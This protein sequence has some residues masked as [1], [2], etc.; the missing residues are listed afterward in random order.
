MHFEVASLDHSQEIR[1]YDIHSGKLK[2]IYL[3]HAKTQKGYKPTITE[4][5]I[6]AGQRKVYLSYSSGDIFLYNSKNMEFI[7]NVNNLDEDYQ[8]ILKQE[9]LALCPPEISSLTSAE[10]SKMLYLPDDEVLIV[11]TASGVIKLYNEGTGETGLIKV[12]VGGHLGSEITML[13]YCKKARLLVSGS[14]NGIATIWNLNTNKLEHVCYSHP[15]KIVGA[16]ILLP[17]PLVVI[18]NQVG[19]ITVWTLHL[20]DSFD[21][22]N[23]CILNLLNFNTDP[24]SVK[25]SSSIEEITSFMYFHHHGKSLIKNTLPSLKPKDLINDHS[26]SHSLKS[27]T[28]LN[29]TL[30]DHLVSDISSFYNGH[31]PSIHNNYKAIDFERCILGLFI[32]TEL[33]CD[34]QYLILGSSRGSLIML[35]LYI[36]VRLANIDKADVSELV[37]M[38]RDRL[39]K[40][41]NLC[42]WKQVDRACKI[43]K[44][45]T[46][47]IVD[48]H[49]IEY[50]VLLARKP[51]GRDDKYGTNENT[52]IK[53][54]GDELVNVNT[55]CEPIIDISYESSTSPPS[56]LVITPTRMMMQPFPIISTSPPVSVINVRD[57][58]ISN[59]WHC[60]YDWPK[61]IVENYENVFEVFCEI[62]GR[63]KVTKE[64]VVA[65]GLYRAIQHY[66]QQN[67]LSL[68][69]R[70]LKLNILSTKR[71]PSKLTLESQARGMITT[72]QRQVNTPAAN[73][74]TTLEGLY[75]TKNDKLLKISTLTHY[76][77]PEMN[78][79]IPDMNIS[80]RS[81]IRR[82]RSNLGQSA[83]DI[84]TPNNHEHGQFACLIDTQFD[85]IE[86][87]SKDKQD[88]SERLMEKIRKVKALQLNNHKLRKFRATTNLVM[89]TNSLSNS[90]AKKKEIAATELNQKNS[91]TI[92]SRSYKVLIKRTESPMIKK[93][94]DSSINISNSE[95]NLKTKEGVEGTIQFMENLRQKYQSFN[96]SLKVDSSQISKSY[97]RRQKLRPP[98]QL[99]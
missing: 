5:E 95:R 85:T 77:D 97:V 35:D 45:Q 26:P 34:H 10:V 29:T 90:F 73:K 82:S 37:D 36:Y 49:S 75:S 41:E 42:V 27:S 53:D 1:F 59:I 40:P 50:S 48:V 57:P 52:M 33:M 86:R 74:F 79:D 58:S 38:K 46:T 14:A 23:K 11:G 12:F 47:A 32:G 54:L 30:P 67:T 92:T 98:K 64:S 2:S 25:K 6:G 83:R 81:N 65:S 70:F 17:Y 51:L 87:K 88:E 56:L 28:S 78:I 44:Q 62:E 93:S 22:K 60:G 43:I 68:T 4:F 99:T 80:S 21:Y 76:D 66:T 69:A 24:E 55:I 94:R 39:L 84:Y 7:K 96:S 20:S 15:S 89:F 16:A 31:M 63:N 18:C 71:L 72:G 3:N 61:E 19:L 13:Y 91:K 9:Q 8:S